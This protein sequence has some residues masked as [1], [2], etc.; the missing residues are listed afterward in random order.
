MFIVNELIRQIP[1]LVVQHADMIACQILNCALNATACRA[2]Y[3]IG[4]KLTLY[5]V[6]KKPHF[7]SKFTDYVP[8]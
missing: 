7:Q 2:Y 1:V 4:A 8:C 5:S 3:L 6:F